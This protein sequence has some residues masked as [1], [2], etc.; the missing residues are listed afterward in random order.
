MK[1]EWG[2]KDLVGSIIMLL[3]VYRWSTWSSFLF[4]NKKNLNMLSGKPKV[5]EMKE[6]VGDR[7]A[8]VHSENWIYK[9][10]NLFTLKKNF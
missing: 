6:D 4:L 10:Q 3:K 7:E 1:G 9:L 8:P 2:V 5:K